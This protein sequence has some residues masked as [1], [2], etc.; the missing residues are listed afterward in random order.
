MVGQL[1]ASASVALRTFSERALRN[2]PSA[3]SYWLLC[4]V[5]ICLP[6]TRSWARPYQVRTWVQQGNDRFK[7]CYDGKPTDLFH[8]ETRLN[9][10]QLTEMDYR[11]YRSGHREGLVWKKDYIVYDWSTVPKM[12]GD[13]TQPDLDKAQPFLDADYE[14]MKNGDW[15]CAPTSYAIAHNYW[16][17][18]SLHSEPSQTTTIGQFAAAMDTNDVNQT[19]NNGDHQAWYGTQWWKN[20]TTGQITDSDAVLGIRKMS[21]EAPWTGHYES[22]ILWGNVNKNPT[23]TQRSLYYGEIRAGRPTGVKIDGHT[24]I[25]VDFKD[26]GARVNDP[27]DGTT[28]T[29]AWGPIMMFTS[30]QPRA[31]A[32]AGAGSKVFF[33]NDNFGTG[34]ANAQAPG[35]DPGDIFGSSLSGSYGRV[36]DDGGGANDYNGGTVTNGRE[37]PFDIDGMDVLLSIQPMNYLSYSEDHGD[38]NPH[39]WVPGVSEGNAGCNPGEL[40]L[41]ELPVPW[42]TAG[43]FQNNLAAFEAD[44]D[45]LGLNRAES[46]LP[47]DPLDDDVDAVDLE[48]SE[49]FA[50]SVDFVDTRVFPD[51]E[52]LA[53]GGTVKEDASGNKF[54]Y[55]LDGWDPTDIYGA[56]SYDGETIIKLSENTD[57]DAIQFFS[58]SDSGIIDGLLFSVDGDAP[59]AKDAAG[60]PLDPGYVYLSWLNGTLPIPYIDIGMDVDAITWAAIPEPATFAML[61]VG[62]AVLLCRRKTRC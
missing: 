45:G 2:V 4:F 36:W 29:Q 34:Q 47:G 37:Y 58:L 57:I 43:A 7:S 44:E 55:E 31:L 20:D 12:P 35:G 40:S 52:V 6:A 22:N 11:I 30:Q 26:T 56:A 53:P 48:F 49:L 5:L 50:Y 25:G 17:N 3:S 33:S 28:K 39:G 9:Y 16:H 51:Y 23:P 13:P 27:A 14:E 46:S 54:W 15:H 62:G 41:I 32:D 38:P 10:D 8:N 21:P 19:M 18:D 42:Y 60:N 24:M 61:A 1:T 59:E